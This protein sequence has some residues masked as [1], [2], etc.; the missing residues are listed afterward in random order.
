MTESGAARSPWLG[1]ASLLPIAIALA[2]AAAFFHQQL[3]ADRIGADYAYFLPRLL[4]GYYWYTNNGLSPHW[5]TAAF[6]GGLVAYAD[7]QSMYYSLFQFLAHYA[8]PLDAAFIGVIA[9]AALGG[10]G[11]SLLLHSV[12]GISR[13]SAALG[14]AMFVANGFFWT[15]ALTGHLTWA[16][17]MLVPALAGLLLRPHSLGIS[18]SGATLAGLLLASMVYAGA[19]VVAIPSLYAVTV[20]MAIA[21]LAGRG[22]EWL[23]VARGSAIAAAVALAVSA[24]KLVAVLA[25]A[26]NFPRDYYPLPGF[27]SLSTMLTTLA[28]GLFAPGFTPLRDSGSLLVN[29]GKI[30]VSR[31]EFDFRVGPIPPLLIAWALLRGRAQ[32]ARAWSMHPPGANAALVLV[33]LLVLFPIVGN[34]HAPGWTQWLKSLPVI[35]SMSLLLRFWAAYVPMLIVIA[36]VLAEHSGVLRPLRVRAVLLV[37]TLLWIGARS[38]DIGI[39]AA[40]EPRAI[41]AAHARVAQGREAPRIDIVGV[42]V[43]A[44]GTPVLPVGRDDIIAR[45]A[46]QLRC[47][48]PQFGYFL[49]R[50]PAGPLRSGSL[51][52]ESDGRLNMKNPACYSEGEAN[53]CVPGDHFRTGEIASARSLASYRP[54][55]S[56]FS[57]R[58]KVANWLSLLALVAALAWLARPAILGAWPGR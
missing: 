45:N 55:D 3:Y 22:T 16:E 24:S 4:D 5:Y 43:D 27:E 14:G 54:F 9:Y 41:S 34:L 32:I 58:Q 2:V 36:I 38:W 53:G 33:V 57:M 28:Q 20:L 11:M 37:L 7:A 51:F 39:V 13:A 29:T 18:Y 6:C 26:A 19:L 8:G 1:P 46:S 50:F 48:Q 21:G 52:A 56:A 23:A 25:F 47:Y 49:E 44:S 12:F 42:Y 35:G 40:Y 31:E 30:L 10:V 15:R 17:F